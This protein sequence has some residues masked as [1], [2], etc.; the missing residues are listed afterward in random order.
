[1]YELCATIAIGRT[2]LCNLD[3]VCPFSETVNLCCGFGAPFMPKE[4]ENLGMDRWQIATRLL[5][6]RPS[7]GATTLHH[8]VTI[9]SN[10]NSK[11]YLF[12]QMVTATPF[13]L[14]WTQYLYSKLIGISSLLPKPDGTWG[15]ISEISRSL[16]AVTDNWCF[17]R[18]SW[19]WS[20]HAA[21]W[22]IFLGLAF[23]SRK[24][25]RLRLWLLILKKPH[26]ANVYM[27]LWQKSPKYG[28]GWFAG[29]CRSSVCFIFT[30]IK[31]HIL[32]QNLQFNNSVTNLNLCLHAKITRR[33]DDKT[34]AFNT[35]SLFQ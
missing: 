28:H 31:T 18:D 3:A 1:M 21:H 17:A 26:N 19:L 32:G 22:K 15:K 4:R 16:L 6:V 27:D 24:I 7:D 30:N 14:V 34:Q 29:N 2:Y 11:Y 23:V 13:Q 25:S 33:A 5:W 10:S 35:T 8:A 12:A 20:I 9:P